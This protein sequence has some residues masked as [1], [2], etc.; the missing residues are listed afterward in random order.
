MDLG[1][2]LPTHCTG[3]LLVPPKTIQSWAR[4]AE[5][6]GFAGLWALSH[7]VKPP[8]YNTAFLD[9]LVALSHAAAVTDEIPLGTAVLLLP[10]RNTA[11]VASG[12]LSLQHLADRPVTLGVGSGNNPKEFEVAG[13]P[14]NERG[15]RLT[16]G[17]EVLAELFSGEC[18]YDGRFHRFEDVRVDPTL[19][20]RPRIISGG[21][22]NVEEGEYHFPT[23]IL[24]RI[25][26]ADGWI[27]PPSPTEKLDHDWDCV[28]THATDRGVD[29]DG[30]DRIGLQYIHLVDND[31]PDT[32]KAEQR[33]VFDTYY[34]ARGFGHA[35]DSCLVGTTAE[36][37]E[38]LEDY[39]RLGFEE[40]ILGPATHDPGQLDQQME[41]MTEHLLPEFL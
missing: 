11:D 19:A 26:D 9:P 2:L 12:A 3:D 1:T 14:M 23:P 35:A 37:L 7:P 8:I 27:S 29:P 38:R 4:R 22:S 28:R 5:S 25:L 20:E 15:P 34:G 24:D 21:S 16:E 39:D 41:L 36:I 40:V 30:I 17:I 33:D 6:N 13:V 10:L 31:D 32:V 18:S